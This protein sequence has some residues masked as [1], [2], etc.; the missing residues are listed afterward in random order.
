MATNMDKSFPGDDGESIDVAGMVGAIVATTCKEVDIVIGKPSS[1]MAKAALQALQ[2]PAEQCVVIG[3]SLVSDI[4]MGKQFGMRTALVLSGS[5]NRMDA[6]V[7]ED[8]PD[9]IWESLFGL[10]EHYGRKESAV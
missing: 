2:L 8:H 10:V 7:A 3:D 9:W 1:Y 5:T 4:R 6:E